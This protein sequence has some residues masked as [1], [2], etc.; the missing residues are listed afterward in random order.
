MESLNTEKADIRPNFTESDVELLKVYFEF[1]EKYYWQI[2]EEL[3]AALSGHPL[4]GPILS[5]MSPEQQQE[6][7]KR[8]L[9]LQRAAIYENKWEAYTQD[10]IAQG[11]MYARMDVKYADWYEVVQLYKKH[12]TPYIKKD[13]G[14]DVNKAMDVKDG[15]GKL[16]DY[17][18]YGIAEA[19]F[20]EKNRVINEMNHDLEQ[21][22]EQRT[23]ELVEI[24]KELGSFSYTVS[25]DLRAPLRAIDGFAKIL[26]KKF[27]DQLGDEGRK[28]IG[29]VRGNV[30]KMGNL[31]DDLLAFSRLGRMERNTSTFSMKGLF[32]EV[33]DDLKQAEQGRNIEL[34]TDDMP[35]VKADREMMKH[36]AINLLGNAIKFTGGREHGKIE[37]GVQEMNGEQV[38]FVK[39]NGA[40]FDMRYADNLFG[41]FQRLHSDDEFPGTGVGLAIVQRIIHKHQGRIWAEARPDE[42][43]TFYFT[44]KD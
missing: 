43:A 22:V 23:A 21:R 33:F 41:I 15:L 10:L 25:H 44:L 42:G 18:M 8:S 5:A 29:I 2:N 7:N 27:S 13:F 19:Y 20:R 39:D 24:N 35:D 17:A 4:F 11:V 1:N 34:I 14:N 12:L 9:E 31:I 26:D 32:R 37:M 40:G 3:T 6:Q 16:I 28:Y 38:F 30:A 36:V